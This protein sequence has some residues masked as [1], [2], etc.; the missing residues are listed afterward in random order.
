MQYSLQSLMISFIV[1]AAAVA[2]FGLWGI[3]VA[4]YLVL[5]AAIIRRTQSKQRARWLAFGMFI[6]GIIL[7]LLAITTYEHNRRLEW[8]AMIAEHQATLAKYGAQR[9]VLVRPDSKS[10]G[11]K[12][13]TLTRPQQKPDEQ[14]IFI[15]L[16]AD[17][18]ETEG[19]VLPLERIHEEL[20]LG[21]KSKL[22]LWC[23]PGSCPWILSEKHLD[24]I[25]AN[26]ECLVAP[27]YLRKKID[28]LIAAGA[29]SID[30]TEAG[31][32]PERI[33]WPW[34]GSVVVLILS[35]SLLIFRPVHQKIIERP[36]GE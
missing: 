27:A 30:V 16:S 15:Y 8:N 2:A 31:A 12:I 13:V 5:C 35:E 24:V 4:G 33:N 25:H 28:T 9:L 20:S 29:T 10:Q 6:M 17:F 3:A 18:A 26:R 1:V 36:K 19:G 34:I 21:E 22:F 32:Y 11:C 14:S 23:P 7:S